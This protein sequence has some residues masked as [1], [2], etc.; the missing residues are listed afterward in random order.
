MIV[1]NPS[2]IQCGPPGRPD[3]AKHAHSHEGIEVV[4]DGLPRKFAP[5]AAGCLNNKLGISVPAFVF[6]H[7]QHSLPR[8]GEPKP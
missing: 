5:P 7:V 6:H 8:R 3:S 1:T 2:F 4:I